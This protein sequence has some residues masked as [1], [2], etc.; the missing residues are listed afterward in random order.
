MSWKLIDLIF[1]GILS[2]LDSATDVCYDIQIDSGQGNI[3]TALIFNILIF[4]IF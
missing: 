1:R 4:L 3:S 2:E